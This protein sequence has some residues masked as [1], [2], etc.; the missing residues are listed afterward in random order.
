M[1]D[2]MTD[3]GQ[4]ISQSCNTPLA[5][6]EADSIYQEGYDDGFDGYENCP[7]TKGSPRYTVWLSGYNNGKAESINK[8]D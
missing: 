5:E 4:T 3:T 1:E 7:Y 8:K 2:Q 6:H